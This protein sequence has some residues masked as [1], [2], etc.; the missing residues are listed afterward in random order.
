MVTGSLAE[1]RVRN[2]GPPRR[3]V[4]VLAGFIAVLLLA[5][6]GCAH[7]SEAGGGTGL[8]TTR[9]T[10][11][12]KATRSA[13]S[14]SAKPTTDTVC[15]DAAD[16]Q[17][18]LTTLMNLDFTGVGGVMGAI[19]KVQADLKA[20]RANVSSEWKQQVNALSRELSRLRAA[21]SDLGDQDS[22]STA[23]QEVR[24][25]AAD[26]GASADQLRASLS[27]ICPGLRGQQGR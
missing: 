6:A 5:A 18:S 12:V 9:A 20:L 16:L 19:S 8:T 15:K 7:G 14:P 27:S 1:R 2:P 21:V 13:A 25:A 24:D 26:V 4:G 17:K 22:S 11:T 23:W 3:R 10:P